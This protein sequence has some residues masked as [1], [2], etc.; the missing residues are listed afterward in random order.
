MDDNI[1]KREKT[2]QYVPPVRIPN[3][4]YEAVLQNNSYYFIIIKY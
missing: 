1:P 2:K 3:T 4:I